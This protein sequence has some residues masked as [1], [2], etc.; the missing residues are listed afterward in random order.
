[1]KYAFECPYAFKQ[2]FMYGFNPPID[3]ALGLGK[4]L[5]DCLFELHDRALTGDDTSI[6]AVDELIDRHLH[7]PFAY[8]ELRAS[9]VK[10]AKK[11]LREYIEQRGATFPEIEHAE[12]P[13][14]LDAGNGV[15][16]AGRIDLIRR[17][18]TDEVVVIDFKSNDRTQAEEVT[19]LQLQVYALGYKQATGRDASEVVVTNLDDLENDRELPVTEESL[20]GALSAVL[21]VADL[22][23]INALPKEPRGS[24]D[25][26]RRDTCNRCDLIG[27]CRDA[28]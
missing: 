11:R 5:H 15:R 25:A 12:R 1:L 10:S 8:P 3:E 13:I 26:E 4:G 16:V 20:C 7:V 18:D 14:E 2:R 23:R 17:R 27:L 28:V 22:L 21:R 24:T 9:L 19:D 6:A